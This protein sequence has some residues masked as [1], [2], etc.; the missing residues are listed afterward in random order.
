MLIRNVRRWVADRKPFLLSLSEPS[1]PDTPCTAALFCAAEKPFASTL[2][3][4]PVSDAVLWL[5]LSQ[6]VRC[7]AGIVAK[8]KG[9][10][11]VKE[12]GK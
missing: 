5:R 3:S 9:L 11:S 2:I 1:T 6:P 7:V 8:A 12:R 4:S 10:L